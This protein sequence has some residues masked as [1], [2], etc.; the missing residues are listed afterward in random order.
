[1]AAI[2]K[3]SH[4][5]TSR[6]KALAAEVVEPNCV[7]GGIEIDEKRGS[8]RRTHTHT[9]VISQQISTQALKLAF[10]RAIS[11]KTGRGAT[12]PIKASRTLSLSV[13]FLRGELKWKKLCWFSE[14]LIQFVELPESVTL[15][16][17]LLYARKI[18]LEKSI[19]KWRKSYGKLAEVFVTSSYY[20]GSVHPNNSVL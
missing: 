9:Q 18:L 2:K 16:G 11:A 1:M 20:E 12:M 5:R 3:G 10:F 19:A 4:S 13:G 6:T 8:D 17:S 15:Y 14:R 7:V